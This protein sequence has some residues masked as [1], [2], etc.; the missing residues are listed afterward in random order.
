MTVLSAL[1]RR[2]DTP[3]HDACWYERTDAGWYLDGT[4]VFRSDGVPAALR[5]RVVCDPAWR[6]RSGH[7][8]GRVGDQA[9]DLA[10][11]R[12]AGGWT[13]DGA[14]AAG[15]DACEHLD[16]GFTPA[17]NFP[18]IRQLALAVGRAA[19]LPVAW[20]DVPGVARLEVL[21]QRYER[22]SDETYWYES[23]T[24]S[25]AGLLE[26]TPDGIIRRYPDLWELEDGL[27]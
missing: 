20:I 10:I 8:E 13:L 23:P 9:I 22:R 26:L 7:V 14:V 1:W 25:Y 24:A 6:T 11:E 17:T 12:T 18:Q 21:P 3:G 15:L 2:I 16:F 4:A 19:D 27:V 5:Y